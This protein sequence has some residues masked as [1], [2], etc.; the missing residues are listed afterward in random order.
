MPPFL[1]LLF[2]LKPIKTVISSF[3]LTRQRCCKCRQIL[4]SSV[5]RYFHHFIE[6]TN[7]NSIIIDVFFYRLQFPTFMNTLSTISKMVIHGRHACMHY[8]VYNLLAVVA[9]PRKD[10]HTEGFSIFPYIFICLYVRKYD[11]NRPD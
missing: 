10:R 2:P 5:E 11:Q 1:L 4:N 6:M 9:G 7:M 3:H 8:V